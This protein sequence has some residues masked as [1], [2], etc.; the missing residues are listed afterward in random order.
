MTLLRRRLAAQQAYALIGPEAGE[1]FLRRAAPFHQREVLLHVALPGDALLFIV[2]Q[3][4]F[5]RGVLIAVGVAALADFLQ[6]IP[7]I[8]PFGESGQR[9]FVVQPEV[10][11]ELNLIFF[12]KF[13]KALR[14]LLGKTD[15]I[16]YH[17]SS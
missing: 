1:K 12:E 7:Q 17:A 5:C 9:G 8:L 11:Q 16:Q 4:L 10:R 14:A 6:K 15:S 3:N 13:K 2:I